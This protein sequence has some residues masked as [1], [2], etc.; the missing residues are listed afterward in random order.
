[1]EGWE[2]DGEEEFDFHGLRWHG[3]DQSFSN[4]DI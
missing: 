1:M 2:T 4:K 3:S